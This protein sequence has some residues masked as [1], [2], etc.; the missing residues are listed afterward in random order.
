MG[1]VK[2]RWVWT[3]L[4]LPP[5][6]LG[7]LIAVYMAAAGVAP[8][9][10]GAEAIV[11]RALPYL[12][13]INHLSLFALLVFV[14]KRA[15]ESLEAIGWTTPEG[16][17]LGRELILGG[18]CALGIYLFKELGIDSLEAV[19]AGR[20]PTF[21]SL[22]RF[23]PSSL[24]VALAVA[25]TTLPFVEESIYRG[26]ALARLEGRFG[27]TAAVVISS[28]FFGFLHWGN[29]PFAIL[30]TALIGALLACIFVWRRNLVVV[31]VAHALY[32][33]AVLLT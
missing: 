11:R 21:T 15:G 27:T 26:F 16:T 30:A 22:F 1:G 29:G 18:A 31:T 25:A 7:L 14:L 20:S 4:V 3:F 2:R 33:F 6:T 9:D 5:L 12:L 28:I 23:R 32:N 24:D 19:L 13:A 10:P 8:S 17:S